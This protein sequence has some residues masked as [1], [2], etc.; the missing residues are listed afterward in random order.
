VRASAAEDTE[1]VPGTS[2]TPLRRAASRAASLLP[3][4]RTVS[5]R[6][7]TKVSPSASQAAANPAFSARKP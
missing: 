5:L 2:G 6:G 1:S 7:P 4:A 3:I